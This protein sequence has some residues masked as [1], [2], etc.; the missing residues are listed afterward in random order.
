MNVTNVYYLDDHYL[1]IVLV[2]MNNMELSLKTRNYDYITHV[3]PGRHSACSIP[4][5]HY[6]I[7]ILSR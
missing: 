5:V 6:T 7:I 1:D 2:V 3:V 4:E